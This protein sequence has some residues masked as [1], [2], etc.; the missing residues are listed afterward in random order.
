MLRARAAPVVLLPFAWKPVLPESVFL[1]LSFGA[2]LREILAVSGFI[3]TTFFNICFIYKYSILYNT[4]F[5]NTH[6]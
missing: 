5:V 4:T 1:T 6:H 3:G 2:E